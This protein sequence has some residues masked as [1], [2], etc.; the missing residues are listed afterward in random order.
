MLDK[1]DGEIK[2]TCLD[3]DDINDDDGEVEKG[4]EI[5]LL[6]PA[7]LNYNFDLFC[8]IWIKNHE[9]FKRIF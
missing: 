5:F 6:V 1:D 4:S 8:G 2:Q 9:N 3:D 7:R